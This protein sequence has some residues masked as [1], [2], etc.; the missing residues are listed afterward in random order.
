MSAAGSMSASAASTAAVDRG[1]VAGRAHQRR[2]RRCRPDRRCRRDWSSPSPRPCRPRRPSSPVTARR[3][4]HSRRSCAS[5]SH[6]HSRPAGS[7]TGSAVRIS[8]SPRAVTKALV[9]V[10]RRHLAAALRPDQREAARRGTASTAGMSLPGSPLATLP[11]IVPSSA[12]ADR[13]SAAPPRAGSGPPRPGR[14]R[15]SGRPASSSRRSGRSPPSTA[16]PRSSAMSCRST[17]CPMRRHAQFHHRDQAVPARQ[18]PAPRRHVRSARPSAAADV[19]RS[20]ILERRW[21]HVSSP[22]RPPLPAAAAAKGMRRPVAGPSSEQTGNAEFSRTAKWLHELRIHGI[23][24]PA[25]R[26]PR[27]AGCG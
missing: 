20:M 5:A 16:I 18:S 22:R 11:P 27:P 17:R 9:E 8:S 19:R 13:Q 21:Y 4:S 15:R 23:R 25:P 24:G 14:M 1:S 10:A 3:P 7:G 6:R 2:P 12:P 26:A